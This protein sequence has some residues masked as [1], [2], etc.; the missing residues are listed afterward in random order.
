M[1]PVSQRFA[2]AIAGTYQIAASATV[3]GIQGGVYQQLLPPPGQTIKVLSGSV[4]TDTT[5]AVRRT[6]TMTLA[7]PQG[8]LTPLSIPGAPLSPFGTEIQ[9]SSGVTYSDGT[10]E[11]IPLGIFALTTVNPNFSGADFSIAVQGSDRGATVGLRAL[12]QPVSVFTG[13][14]VLSTIQTLIGSLLPNGSRLVAAPGASTALVDATTFNMADNPWADAFG[15]AQNAGLQ[16]YFDV[17]GNAQLQPVPDPSTQGSSWSF[18]YGPGSMILGASRT[19][20]QVGVWNDFIVIYEGTGTTASSNPPIQGVYQDTNPLSAT[21][22]NGP[23]GDVPA[24]VY[25]AVLQGQAA[26]NAAAKQLLLQSLGTADGLALTTMPVPMLDGYDVVTVVIPKLGI[27]S[28]YVVQAV[29]TPIGMGSA[30]LTLRKV[31]SP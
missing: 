15:V 19:L 12:K 1:F 29:T 26:A 23:L 13:Q 5:Q 24:F 17:P 18:V 21:N 27:S 9:V 28:N 2:T 25:T 30:S 16:L 7:D 4:T 31:L 22:V 14:S 6:L 8:W 3:W 20:T 11:Q 10:T